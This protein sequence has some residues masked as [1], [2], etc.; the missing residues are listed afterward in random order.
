MA[1][2]G[3]EFCAEHG[4]KGA[5]E[6]DDDGQVVTPWEVETTDDKG[7]GHARCPHA[8]YTDASPC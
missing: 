2:A 4:T 8:L 6:A 1:A 5:A 7:K 3:K